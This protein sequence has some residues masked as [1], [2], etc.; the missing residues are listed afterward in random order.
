MLLGAAAF[1][2][3]AGTSSGPAATARRRRRLER[4]RRSS[5]RSQY[6]RWAHERGDETL[7]RKALERVAGELGVET[8]Q[9][10]STSCHADRARARVVVAHARATRRS[11]RCR[12]ARSGRQP[13]T[14]S[15]RVRLRPLGSLRRRD[16]VQLAELPELRTAALRTSAAARRCSRSRSRGR[17]RCSSTSPARPAAD[18]P[19]CSRRERR[20]GVVALDMSASISG[21]DRTRGSRRR[22]AASSTRTSRSGSSCS[23]TPRTSCCRRTRRRARCCSSSRSSRRCA[24]TAARPCS[25]SRRGTTSA[26]ARALPSASTEARQ[27]LE[28]AHMCSTARSS[29]SATSTT[30]A[31]DQP[32]LA[33]EALRL[34]QRAHRACASCRCSPSRR[35][36]ATSPRS[37]ATT[38]SSTRASSRTPRSARAAV[39]AAQPWALLALGVAARR[40]PRRQRALERPALGRGARMRHV[41]RHRTALLALALRRRRRRC[42]CCSRSTRAR[43]A[44]RSPS[45]DL[46][47]RALPAHTRP[48]EA[49]DVA[50]R[51][52]AGAAARHRR[53]DGI[54]Q[55]A[56]VLLV[57]PHRLEPGVAPGPADTAGRGAAAA[58]RDLD[59]RRAQRAR[60]VLRREPARRP[61]RHDAARSAATTAR[62]EADPQARRRVLPAGDRRS[63][64]ANDDAKQNLELV[65]RVTKP[66][67]RTFGKDARSGYG[68]GRGRGADAGRQRVLMHGLSFLT[69]LDALFALA[70][71]LPARR[72]PRH[73]AARRH[74]S[75]ACSRCRARAAAPSFRWSSRSS[76]LHVARRGRRRTAG[77]RAPASS[78][79]S[80]RTHRRSSSSTRRCRCGVG[81]TRQADAARAREADRVAAS[82]PRSRD[83]PV[84]IASMTDRS[85]PNLMPTTDRA[86]FK[87]TLAQS[88]RHRPA[89]AE[90]GC[91][92][93]ARD[94][95]PGAR[96]ARRVALLLAGRPAA[97]ARRLHRRR[98]VEDLAVPQHHAPPARRRRVFVHVWAAG[99]ADLQRDGDADP[100]YVSD[101]TSAAALDQV[102]EITGGR[103]SF[104]E[105]RDGPR[106]RMRRAT[107][108]AMR[109]HATHVDAY[110]RV[111][112]APWFVLAG[113]VP[114]AFLLW[115]RNL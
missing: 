96:P 64:P 10:R 38:R 27:A 22:C 75:G 40:A 114:L 31:A 91:T 19:P 110:A 60:A 53:H 79:A 30:P 33:A 23:P 48:L 7:Q 57:Q 2:S 72:A 80:G 115:R 109:R 106:S 82:A 3:A 14:R 61:R 54:P 62:I 9:P 83:V 55:G 56:A 81:R 47:F 97:A 26:A 42:S 24:T 63:T 89:A 28:R 25:R 68:F 95:V 73:G 78:S 12:S 21:P 17:S 92:R 108:S 36:S 43:G 41:R 34:R 49:A 101:P 35:T 4:A 98:G 51:R 107:R 52:P 13:E 11:R 44:R 18:A 93:D 74:G 39:A 87:R 113:I 1:A 112:L 67:K 58:R 69:P 100:N 90:P 70:A 45:D 5:V 29:S 86:L 103:H 105:E 6:S 16:P 102:A 99:R 88:V 77:R 85:L 84:G 65:L 50:A 94:D 76:L 8:P 37:S 32:A 104:T 111:A 59:R 15:R 20:T 66:G 46:R 71:A